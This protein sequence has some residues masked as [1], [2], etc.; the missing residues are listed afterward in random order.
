MRGAAAWMVHRAAGVVLVAGMAVH[1]GVLHFSGPDALTYE[2]VS[3][4]LAS[5]GWT[6][7]N[8][9]LLLS[10][11]YHGLHGLWGLALEYVSSPTLR[12]ASLAILL[13]A[14]AVLSG[15]GIYI[16]SLG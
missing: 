2:A 13:G 15:A 1:F 7:F 5:P 9:V 16:L 8:F 12:R 4:R 14:S 11:I 10:A 3:A 6:A